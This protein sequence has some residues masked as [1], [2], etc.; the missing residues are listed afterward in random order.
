MALVLAETAVGGTAV[1]WA[2][3]LRGKVRLAFYKLLGAVL[4][5]FAVLAWLAAR[6]P[7]GGASATGAKGVAFWLLAATAAVAV[8][9][10]VLLW[11]AF[12]ILQGW[13]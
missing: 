7:L 6:A 1:L 8:V 4:A 2:T 9:W 10:Q 13:A 11:V 3:P 5:A 12:I